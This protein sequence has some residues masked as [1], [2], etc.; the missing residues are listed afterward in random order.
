M[1]TPAIVDCPWCGGDAEIRD[2]ASTMTCATCGVEVAIAP[3]PAPARRLAA[4]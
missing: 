1:D 2:A 4:A 3:D